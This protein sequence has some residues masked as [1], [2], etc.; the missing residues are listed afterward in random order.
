MDNILSIVLDILM[1]IV[2]IGFVFFMFKEI[3]RVLDERLKEN[4]ESLDRNKDCEFL[5]CAACDLG[6]FRNAQRAHKAIG[7]V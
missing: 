1:P 4:R 7:V 2:V 6:D 5:I 3:R